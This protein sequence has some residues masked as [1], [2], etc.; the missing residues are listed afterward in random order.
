[1]MIYENDCLIKERKGGIIYTD[2]NTHISAYTHKGADSMNELQYV[3]RQS[4]A[5]DVVKALDFT[6]FDR[7]ISF[8]DASP[9]TVE[10]YK[11]SP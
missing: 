6:A 2:K 5:V 8:L 7:F 11:K 1:M 9:K 3:E 4:N 10:T